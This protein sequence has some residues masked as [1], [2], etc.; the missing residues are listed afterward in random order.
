DPLLPA[1]ERGARQRGPYLL[2]DASASMS[3]PVSATDSSTRWEAAWNE[4]A[5][6]GGS[7]LL[8]G[9]RVR[10]GDPDSLPATL[11]GDGRSQVLPALGAAAE[12]GAERVV[13]ITDGELEGVNTIPAWLARLGLGVEW[14]RVGEPLGGLSLPDVGAPAWAEAGSEIELRLTVAA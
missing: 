8:F 9:D 1:A 13:V 5:R 12:S 4:A 2:L 3:L 6:R 11:P 14:L 10:P 7:V